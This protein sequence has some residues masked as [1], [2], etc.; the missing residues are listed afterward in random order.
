VVSTPATV[1][2]LGDKPYS[3][4]AEVVNVSSRGMRLAT[5]EP[6]PADAAIRVHLGLDQYLGEVTHCSQDGNRYF[7]GI[8]LIN[9]MRN[10]AAVTER[11]NRILMPR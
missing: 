9:V 7:V 10:A 2:V 3:V 11:L 8:N 4:A 5:A 6:L 1:D